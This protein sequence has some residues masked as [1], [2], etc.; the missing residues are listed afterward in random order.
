METALC[1]P[2]FFLPG[3]YFCCRSA[4]VKGSLR[5]AKHR[6]ALD[7]RGPLQTALP[8]RKSRKK[9]FLLL[10]AKKSRARMPQERRFAARPTHSIPLFGRV[11]CTTGEKLNSVCRDRSTYNAPKI[12]CFS[13]SS[14]ARRNT[15]GPCLCRI[16]CSRSTSSN[17]CRGRRCTISVR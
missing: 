5:R 7:R 10:W 16:W 4:A 1:N 14:I 2:R 11:Y 15:S 9:K 3:R 13:P 12:C 6:R 8:R 17:H